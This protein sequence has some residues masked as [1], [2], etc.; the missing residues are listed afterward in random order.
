[1]RQIVCYNFINCQVSI[2]NLHDSIIPLFIKSD[3]PLDR[4]RI[5]TSNCKIYEID[6]NFGN[7]LSIYD[8]HDQYIYKIPW[9]CLN[10]QQIYSYRM[11]EPILVTITPKIDEPVVATYM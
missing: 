7:K 4:V 6:L 3:V 2:P 1:M 11:F 8:P 5:H 9:E 10:I